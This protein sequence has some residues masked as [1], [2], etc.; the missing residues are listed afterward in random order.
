M[1]LPE[2]VKA[3]F[4][5]DSGADPE[6]LVVQFAADAVVEDEGRRHR[7]RK[8]IRAWWLEAKAKYRHVAEPIDME[9]DGNRALVRARVSG[10]FPNS[11]AMLG[12]AF[13]LENG[14]IAALRIG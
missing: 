3:Y 7:G 9:R 4:D 12:F 6:T 5:A 14:L 10:D 13:T 1:D 8:A 2:P 11:P